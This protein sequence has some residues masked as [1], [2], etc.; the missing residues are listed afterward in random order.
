M[1]FPMNYDRKKFLST[2]IH[3][4]FLKLS[5][6]KYGYNHIYNILLSSYLVHKTKI[7]YKL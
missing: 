5:F 2:I 1:L 4:K 6:I 7:L 3:R